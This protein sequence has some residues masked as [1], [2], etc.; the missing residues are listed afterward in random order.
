MN[1]TENNTQTNVGINLRAIAEALGFDTRT[2]GEKEEGKRKQDKHILD[3][4]KEAAEHFTVN[5]P[6]EQ[7]EAM[8]A[9][10]WVQKMLKGYSVVPNPWI[11][12]DK[13]TGVFRFTPIT[14]EVANIK[15]WGVSG[16]TFAAG[17]HGTWMADRA[18][19][20]AR[21]SHPQTLE[22]VIAVQPDAPDLARKQIAAGIDY[23]KSAANAQE[24]SAWSTRELTPSQKTMYEKHGDLYEAQANN[25]KNSLS[26]EDKLLTNQIMTQHKAITTKLIGDM[27]ASTD[28][29]ARQMRMHEYG[30]HTLSYLLNMKSLGKGNPGMALGEVANYNHMVQ[31]EL[32]RIGLP[33]EAIFYGQPYLRKEEDEKA[34]RLFLNTAWQLSEALGE[35]APK[36]AHFKVLD[37]VV[38][39]AK[40]INHTDDVAP[41]FNQMVVWGK[42]LGYK[43]VEELMKVLQERRPKKGPEKVKAPYEAY[44]Q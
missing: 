32:A 44:E 22:N 3:M 1:R 33:K 40:R 5:V 17:A 31:Q 8:Y 43:R 26:A 15:K 14:E 20:T 19:E 30:S 2:V 36:S 37:N 25:F 34:T 6:K 39:I 28:S 24:A 27:Y 13:E 11:Q 9:T 4:T 29:K 41:I 42:G 12:Q 35:H 23:K 10:D 7:Q 16:P 21:K 38:E 18:A